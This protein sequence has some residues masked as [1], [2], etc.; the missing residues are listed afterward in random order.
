[1]GSVTGDGRVVTAL[2]L[3]SLFLK[4]LNDMKQQSEFNEESLILTKNQCASHGAKFQL[5]F[6]YSILY[7]SL[8]NITKN[9][10]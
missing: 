8:S 9:S 10:F 6:S 1:M 5:M 3:T 4:G 7:T 2:S